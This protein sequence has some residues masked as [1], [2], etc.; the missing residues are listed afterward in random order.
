MYEYS[1]IVLEKIEK[2]KKDTRL[3]YFDYVTLAAFDI[4]ASDNH[5]LTRSVTFEAQF[6]RY[7]RFI[8]FVY[9]GEFVVL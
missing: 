1:D 8:G 3:T 9:S 7:K 4:F 5:G 2:L 6:G